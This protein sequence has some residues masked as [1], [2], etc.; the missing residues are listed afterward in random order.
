MSIYQGQWPESGVP[1]KASIRVSVDGHPLPQAEAEVPG[2]GLEF[3]WGVF[4]P[5]ANR[6]RLAYSLLIYELHDVMGLSRATAHK[7]L[8]D[9]GDSFL[10]GVVD[11]L[12]ANWSLDSEAI[13]QWLSE[14]YP[15]LWDELKAGEQAPV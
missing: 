4:S 7:Y 9:I 14:H 2:V 5:F 1:N 3:G 13:R 15:T 6:K 8:I 10:E 11:R 12:S